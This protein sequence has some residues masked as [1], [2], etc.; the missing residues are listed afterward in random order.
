MAAE[1]AQLTASAR[2]AELRAF[3]RQLLA[4]QGGALGPQ[5]PPEGGVPGLAPQGEAEGGVLPLAQQAR[6]VVRRHLRAPAWAS[7]PSLPLPAALRD[8]VLLADFIDCG[9][10]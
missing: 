10:S 4:P 6:A 1:L 2:S 5:G 7:G 3:Y 9:A 8:F